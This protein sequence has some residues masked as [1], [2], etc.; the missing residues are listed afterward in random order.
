M[1]IYWSIFSL[2]SGERDSKD[3]DGKKVSKKENLREGKSRQRGRSV[4]DI[5]YLASPFSQQ[6]QSVRAAWGDQLALCT[7]CTARLS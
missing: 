4:G 2:I 5:R 7:V 1:F 3:K 6:Y